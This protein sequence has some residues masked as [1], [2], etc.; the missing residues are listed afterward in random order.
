[1]HQTTIS[2]NIIRIPNISLSGK[3]NKKPASAIGVQSTK[4]LHVI[5]EPINPNLN[6]GHPLDEVLVT[7]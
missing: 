2:D 4:K 7:Y 5:K 1:M 6:P 3:S